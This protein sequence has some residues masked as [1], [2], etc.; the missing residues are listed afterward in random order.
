VMFETPRGIEKCVDRPANDGVTAEATGQEQ[1]GKDY[2]R[3]G[4]FLIE[5]LNSV[6]PRGPATLTRMDE[7]SATENREWL[8]HVLSFSVHP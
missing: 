1:P 8:Q 2:V 4:A 3:D 5:S 7:V 6:M